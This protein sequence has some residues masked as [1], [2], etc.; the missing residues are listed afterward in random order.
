[1]P[2]P[3]SLLCSLHFPTIL[4]SFHFPEIHFS[5]FCALHASTLFASL[6]SSLFSSVH[7]SDFCALHVSTLF[8][9]LLTLLLHYSLAS[10]VP[11]CFQTSDFCALHVSTLFASL[12]TSLLHCSLVS[13]VPY[14]FQIS[15]LFIQARLRIN[16]HEWRMCLSFGVCA[17][18]LSRNDGS[19]TQR[20]A[21]Q[22]PICLLLACCMQAFRFA[23]Y[24]MN[25]YLRQV[26]TRGKIENVHQVGSERC[27]LFISL[28]L[29]FSTFRLPRLHFS[30]CLVSTFRHS[31]ILFTSELF[32]S[33]LSDLPT[34]H[35]STL[36]FS[37]FRLPYPL[38][39]YFLHFPTFRLP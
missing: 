23:L 28:S 16:T 19:I 25:C 22:L 36:P 13:S 6:L 17:A 15:L 20:I 1:M 32:S 11:Y 30:T 31:Y 33:L 26:W 8:T 37:T 2:L 9:S 7:S 4:Y 3:S 35:F 29:L 14:F 5:G 39:L 34:L 38:L 27:N 21:A 18:Q 24:M 12:L 10:S